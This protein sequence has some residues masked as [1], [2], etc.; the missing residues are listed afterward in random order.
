VGRQYGLFTVPASTI[1]LSALTKS[2]FARSSGVE[3]VRMVSGAIPFSRLQRWLDSGAGYLGGPQIEPE[4][5]ALIGDAPVASLSWDFTD[6]VN[7]GLNLVMYPTLQRA[8]AYTPF[9]DEWNAAWIRDKGPR[10]LVYD[11][12]AIDNRDPW[13]ETP[14]MWLEIYRWYDTRY[15]GEHNML[16]ERRA[17]PRFRALESIR[18]LSG[19]L[20]GELLIPPSAGPVFWTMKCR[21]STEGLI[22]RAFAGIPAVTLSAH[23]VGGA[24]RESGR[25]IPDVL[26]S[27]VIGNYLPYDLAQFAAL[28]RPDN[29][30]G[31]SYPGYSVDRLSFGGEGAASWASP[32]EVE[33][34]RPV[35]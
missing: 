33:F 11:G 31:G 15:L 19:A 13:A 24:V 2:A 27:P 35:R 6:L 32:C 28:F 16:L 5:V 3:A 30:W 29:S 1:N 7:A 22:R 14:A 12:G 18:R 20:S 17:A 4:L 26:V 21:Y 10:Y 23:E 8:I 9:L 34:L 25:V